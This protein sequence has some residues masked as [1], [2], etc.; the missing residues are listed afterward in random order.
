MNTHSVFKLTSI[1][2]HYLS[3]ERLRLKTNFLNDLFNDILLNSTIKYEW[4]IQICQSK[5]QL[6]KYTISAEYPFFCFKMKFFS[7][8]IFGH[9]LAH[10]VV[11][12]LA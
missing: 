5:L 7:V 2:L 3:F 11:K 1:F 8:L 4:F 10:F 6:L 9:I 12:M